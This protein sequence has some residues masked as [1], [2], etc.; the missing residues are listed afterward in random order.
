MGRDGMTAHPE[1]D[2]EMHTRHRIRPECGCNGSIARTSLATGGAVFID[3]TTPPTPR[4]NHAKSL[5]SLSVAVLGLRDNNLRH[6]GK[7][8]LNKRVPGTLAR[9]PPPRHAA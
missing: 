5:D 8:G 9:L 6:A 3:S 1:Q 4:W 7:S 2:M